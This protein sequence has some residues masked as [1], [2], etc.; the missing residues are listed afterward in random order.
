ML[1]NIRLKNF[2][3]FDEE[4]IDIAPLTLIMGLN[5]MGK[6][7]ILQSL[8]L[9]KQN[10][11]NGSLEKEECQMRLEG[12]FVSLESAQSLCNSWAEERS[13][14]VELTLSNGEESRW[15]IDAT[16]DDSTVLPCM[17][18]DLSQN[19]RS[20]FGDGFAFIGADR[21]V[22]S[23]EYSIV[24]AK[25]Y[26]TKLGVKGELT[27]GYLYRA[28]NANEE[29]GI[30]EMKCP[31]VENLD[32][33]L[34]TNVNAWMSK[35]MSVNMQAL[36]EQIDAQ[37]VRMKYHIG[38][39][40]GE[41]FSPLQVGFGLTYTLPIVTAV[42]MAHPGD[43]LLFEN[44]EAHLHPSAQV[45]LAL[46]FGKEVAHGV[47]ILV[48]THSDHIINGVRMARK[49]GVLKNKNAVNLLFVQRE[50][51]DDRYE[52][53]IND[54]KIEDSG[55]FSEPLPPMFNVWTDTLVKLV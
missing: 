39:M 21:L 19:I 55:K 31:D 4:Y 43:L 26:N 41:Q 50:K 32:T 5:G 23:K 3:T 51:V 7:S 15:N 54:V 40:V 17:C 28:L 35:I 34:V 38:D 6:S 44:P 45:N 47:Q 16:E 53:Y 11:A 18:N 37:Q 33:Q 2:K 10:F 52:S 36:T 14:E 49:D 20:L 42:L 27:P 29:I 48:E 13:V 30:K 22:P 8:L 9:L 25:T 46:L 24:S 12:D 1:S